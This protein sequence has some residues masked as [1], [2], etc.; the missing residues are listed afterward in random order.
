MND[1]EKEKF[2]LE[3]VEKIKRLKERVT[4][5]RKNNENMDD[6]MLDVQNQIKEIKAGS[7]EVF[8]SEQSK[9]SPE[10]LEAFLQNPSNF[11]KDDWSLLETIKSETEE[12]KREIVKLNEKEAVEDLIGKKKKTG[13]KKKHKNRWNGPNFI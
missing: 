13:L 9:M 2:I 4:Q 11:S 6:V 7:E 5:A 3:A 12:C 10:E 1:P 8:D